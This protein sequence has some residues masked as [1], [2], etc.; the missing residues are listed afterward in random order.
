MDP[1]HPD[2]FQ[3]PA[4]PLPP[5]TP[6]DQTGQYAPMINPG[7]PAPEPPQYSNQQA[8]D[9]ARSKIAALHPQP[10]EE[11]AA[12]PPAEPTAQ[13][14]A[15]AAQPAALQP[16]EAPRPAAPVEPIGAGQAPVPVFQPQAAT[17]MPK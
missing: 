5:P 14:E 3:L 7:N 12:P 1:N 8:V 6:T 17:F 4:G 13:P 9:W 16:V 11:T 10:V 15:A 2:P